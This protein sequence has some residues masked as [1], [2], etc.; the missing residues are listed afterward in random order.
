[1]HYLN[2]Q[3]TERKNLMYKL[4]FWVLL[5][6]PLIIVVSILILIS[7]GYFGFM[8]TF[9]DLENPKN[10]V[11]SEVIT[12]DREVLGTYYYQNRFFV[13]QNQISPNLINA[14]I[15]TEDIRFYRFRY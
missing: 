9:E 4:T 5:L 2:M 3:K 12:E 10:N 7:I 13:N 15:A 14:L 1:M 11:A 8:P 6:T